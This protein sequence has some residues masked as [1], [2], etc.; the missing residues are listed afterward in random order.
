MTCVHQSMR[1]VVQCGDKDFS[2]M[3]PDQNQGH[4]IKFLKEDSGT[5]DLYGQHELKEVIELSK[6]EVLMAIDEF[7]S[8]CFSA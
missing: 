7:G 8:A 6:P 4:S 3:A 2:F 1:F 5:N